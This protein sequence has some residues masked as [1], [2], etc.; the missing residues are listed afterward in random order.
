MKGK[1]HFSIVG[2]Y[3]VRWLGVVFMYSLTQFRWSLEEN[4]S[5]LNGGRNCCVQKRSLKNFREE[6]GLEEERRGGDW[7]EGAIDWWLS[8]VSDN[9]SMGFI[10]IYSLYLNRVPPTVRH[11][12]CGGIETLKL[13]W[14]T[15]ATSSHNGIISLWVSLVKFLNRF[16]RVSLNALLYIVDTKVYT[17]TIWRH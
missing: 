16:M 6:K 17:V 1:R 15:S 9:V 12:I 5:C 3:S 10:S 4:N 13:Q 2:F 7:S 11:C 8:V 14:G